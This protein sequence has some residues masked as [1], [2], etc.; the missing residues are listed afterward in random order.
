VWQAGV[1]TDQ[2]VGGTHQ[3]CFSDG[4]D[5]VLLGDGSGTT[6][7]DF[8]QQCWEFNAANT[9]GFLTSC[10]QLAEGVGRSLGE[11]K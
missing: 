10:K 11:G 4:Y 7:P 5:C 8:A 1:N 6:S 2:C 3:D 9:W